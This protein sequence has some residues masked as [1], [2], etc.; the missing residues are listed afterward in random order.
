MG[1]ESVSGPFHVHLI[2]DATGETLHSVGKAAI[3]QFRG[4]PIQEHA[5]TLVRSERQLSRACDRIRENPGLVLF[6][7]VNPKLRADLIARLSIMGIPNFDVMEGPV[8]LMQRVFDTPSQAVIGG[9]HEVDQEYLQRMESLN[10]M[11]EHDDGSNLDLGN[12]E[13]ILVGASRTSKTPTCVYLAMRG[14]RAANVPL[15]LGMEP[16]S[17]LLTFT[18]P[19][20]VG[21]W[22]SPERLVQIRRNRLVT[23]GVQQE[24]DYVDPETVRGEVMTTRRMYDRYGWPSIDVTRRS[25]EET[26]AAILN[27]LYERKAV[28]EAGG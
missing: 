16:P 2:S 19:L 23:M 12:A 11:V 1:N 9:Q 26:A 5:Y 3:A 20:I 4:V 8:G 7:I 27:L 17:Q 25:I 22:V 28:K 10:Y 13:V 6:T 21:L 14:I 24:T 15:V 18:K